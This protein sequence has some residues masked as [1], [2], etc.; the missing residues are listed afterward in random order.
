MVA[1]NVFYLNHP[2]EVRSFK[3]GEYLDIFKDFL[4]AKEKIQDSSKI[5]NLIRKS[6]NSSKV[7]DIQIKSNSKLNDD[8]ILEG[9]LN[10]FNPPFEDKLSVFES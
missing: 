7:E 9:L 4:K 2:I 3:Q 6:S 8:V 10:I 1:F 5:W